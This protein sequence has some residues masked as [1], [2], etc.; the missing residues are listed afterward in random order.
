MT[1]P[2]LTRG[3]LTAGITALVLEKYPAS[4]SAGELAIAT[5]A[6]KRTVER[7]LA[8]LVDAGVLEKKYHSYTLHGKHLSQIFGA[9]W[10]VRQEIEKDI[11]IGKKET[12]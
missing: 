3:R 4:W 1:G 9:R 5:G 2:S 12:A 10:A 8:D 7:V 11:L 6:G